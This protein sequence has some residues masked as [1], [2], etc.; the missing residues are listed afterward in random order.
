MCTSLSQVL[1]ELPEHCVFTLVYSL[2]IYWL[3][4]LNDS[5]DRFLLN[6]MLAWLM[7]YCSRSMALFAAAVLPTLQTSSFMGN[8]LFTVFYLTGGFVIN[9]DNMW[10]G[11]N[12]SLTDTQK[13]D[14]L[15]PTSKRIAVVLIHFFSP[16]VASWFSYISFMRWGF[17]GM[18]Q[19]QFRGVQY[20][21]SLGNLTINVDGIKVRIPSIRHFFP[22]KRHRLQ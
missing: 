21:V 16:S 7:I 15:T 11:K 18:L 8:S 13:Y 19:V 3:A 10:L 17:D 9:L 5:P 4:G 22:T 6:F 2:P 20:S 14:P 1:G 12:R